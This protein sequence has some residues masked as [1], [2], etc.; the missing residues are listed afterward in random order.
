MAE[1]RQSSLLVWLKDAPFPKTAR[2]SEVRD[3]ETSNEECNVEEAD[4]STSG[5]VWR[6]QT[7]KHSGGVW[8]RQTTSGDSMSEADEAETTE[9]CKTQTAVLRLL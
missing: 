4:Y 6:I 9:A 8:L 1:K 5:V 7:L 3:N 2:V